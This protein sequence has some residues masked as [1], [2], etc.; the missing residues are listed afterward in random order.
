MLGRLRWTRLLKRHRR[1]ACDGA[2]I[3]AAFV[4]IS[5]DDD[6]GA[7]AKGFEVEVKWPAAFLNSTLVRVQL[8]R[9]AELVRR[10][11]LIYQLDGDLFLQPSSLR[12][13]YEDALFECL[14]R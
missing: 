14:T 3:E 6:V 1:L 13:L 12:S 2:R 9:L 7:L 8:L 5:N 4:S 11:L 10:R